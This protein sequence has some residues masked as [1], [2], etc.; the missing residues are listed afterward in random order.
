MSATSEQPWMRGCK[1]A[2]LFEATIYI[3]ELAF[4]LYGELL[5][6][7]DEDAYIPYS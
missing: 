2:E 6:E 7:P 5:V 3:G 4:D 1:G